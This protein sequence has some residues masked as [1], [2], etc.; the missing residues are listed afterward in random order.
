[1][2][3]VRKLVRE[4]P[5]LAGASVPGSPAGLLIAGRAHFFDNSSERRSALG[6]P[7]DVVE[8]TLNE[9][10]ENQVAKYLESAGVPGLLPE[11]LPSRPLLVGYLAATRLLMDLK[12]DL[13]DEFD[14]VVGWEYLLDRV[15]ARE[16]EIEAGIDGATVRRILERLATTARASDS[17]LGPLR[18]ESVV[19][20]FRDICGYDP[21]DQGMVL[22]QRLPGL[23]V[24]RAEEE[25]RIFIDD[26][27]ADACRAGDVVEFIISPF[28]FDTGTLASIESAMGSLGIGM[29]Q[30]RAERNGFS[31]GKV[32][33]AIQ[34]AGRQSSP[35]MVADIARLMVT[36]GFSIRNRLVVEGAVVP[37]LE[38]GGSE[39]DVSDLRF[40][41]CFFERV[42]LGAAVEAGA[43]PAFE[44]CYIERLEGRVSRQDLP[45]G[46][47]DKECV[48]DK[49][50]TVTDT[51]ARLLE[52][53][54]P[55]DTRVCLAIL[56]KVYDR[57]GSG[58][59]E[60]A[61]YRGMDDRA[62]RL[63]PD[64]LQVLQSEKLVFR[65]R[66]K[67]DTIWLAG[68][69]RRRAGRLIAAPSTSAD[70]VLTKCGKLVG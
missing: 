6:L 49:F 13:G 30:R 27:F 8:L 43:I 58:R 33:T 40:V 63:V 5:R 25:S 12:N 37:E 28:D 26:T 18:Q 68:R 10:T 55:L 15:A 60:N 45:K 44:G 59:R 36:A 61:L 69:D 11:W 16:A 2:E 23:G 34:H 51:T 35:Y 31:D 62:R 67:S 50:A 22:L 70:S 14:P 47:F 54:L 66:R 3:G 7:N 21:H 4:H 24:Y 9:F 64:V 52:L 39:A 53:D 19:Q 1:M 65:Y 32:N 38:L 48:I 42:E 46:K 20:A 57:R 29:V 56:K 17:G 41:D